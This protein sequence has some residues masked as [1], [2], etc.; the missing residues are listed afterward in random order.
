MVV[1]LSCSYPV[2]SKCRSAVE[3]ERYICSSWSGNTRFQTE[4]GVSSRA[5]QTKTS[6]RLP[7]SWKL[8]RHYPRYSNLHE[9]GENTCAESKKTVLSTDPL[10]GKDARLRINAGTAYI[11]LIPWCFGVY[12]FW[13]HETQGR[14]TSYTPQSCGK[15]ILRP[16]D[17]KH[18]HS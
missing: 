2:H 4:R 16:T 17:L 10:L 12:G 9:N 11:T 6:K 18:V 1:G 14:V 13:S 15:L 8:P 3:P 5:Q 7:S